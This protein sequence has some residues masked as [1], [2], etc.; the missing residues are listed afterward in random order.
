MQRVSITR[1]GVCVCVC[2]RYYPCGAGWWCR[3]EDSLFHYR[4]FQSQLAITFVFEQPL[5]PR[6]CQQYLAQRN[7]SDDENDRF[8]SLFYYLVTTTSTPTPTTTTSTM[9][10]LL[11]V[12]V[13][14]V[15]SAKAAIEG[16]ADRL[17]VC[18]SLLCGGLTPSN[19][20][21]RS[22]RQLNSSIPLFAM[23][24]PRPGDFCFTP[25]EVNQM[26]QEI[27]EI[28]SAN[29]ADGF[30]TGAL[31]PD[32]SVDVDTCNKLLASAELYPVTFHRAF[33]L[34]SDAVEALETIIQLG[35]S[36]ILTSGQCK[37]AK[38]GL[39]VIKMLI[40]RSGDRIVIVAGCG[41]N[42]KNVESILREVI[43][44]EI[45]S[46]ASKQV[47]SSM[48]MTHET[49]T[50]GRCVGDDYVW[51]ECDEK[52][53]MSMVSIM[54]RAVFTLNGPSDSTSS[55]NGTT[56][57]ATNTNGP[58]ANGTSYTN[59][60]SN[61]IVNNNNDN[62]KSVVTSPETST[63]ATD[64]N[65]FPMTHSIKTTSSNCTSSTTS[66]DAPTNGHAN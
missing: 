27:A 42:D 51:N 57:G 65:G 59:G 40:Q 30:V 60:T 22:I 36:R 47:K 41:I 28:K 4:P 3:C 5:Q 34:T 58:K 19:G 7:S 31:C 15:S 10:P 43:I 61:G 8:F 66:I 18:S 24:R 12:C 46:S 32:G 53:V 45:H 35:F 37:N 63:D 26:L 14:S 48:E 64:T 13:D 38:T 16:G 1:L 49:V 29:L 25:L 62:G 21:L 20:L 6:Q 11:E 17:E 2:R 55:E 23:I 39:D 50:L 33:D 56:N 52:V 9:R 54:K 44:K